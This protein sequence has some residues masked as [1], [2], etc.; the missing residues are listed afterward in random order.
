MTNE[1]IEGIAQSIE[2]RLNGRESA[3]AALEESLKQRLDILEV[4]LA[5]IGEEKPHLAFVLRSK[6]KAAGW[7][8]E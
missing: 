6:A 4:A 8:L 3:V 1:Q 5:I 2:E 7:P